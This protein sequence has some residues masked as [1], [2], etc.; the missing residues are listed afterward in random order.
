MLSTFGEVEEGLER[1]QGLIGSHSEQYSIERAK[2]IG[3]WENQR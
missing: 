1:G 2:Q 3:L